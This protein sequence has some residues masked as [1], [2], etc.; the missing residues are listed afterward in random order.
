VRLDESK[1]DRYFVPCEAPPNGTVFPP[2][3]TYSK[4]NEIPTKEVIFERYAVGLT[5]KTNFDWDLEKHFAIRLKEVQKLIYDKSH[6]RITRWDLEKETKQYYDSV[7][8]KD[9]LK[10]LKQLSHDKFYEKEV[11]T[12]TIK[13]SEQIYIDTAYVYTVQKEQEFDLELM[14]KMQTEW[15]LKETASNDKSKY[16]QLDDLDLFDELSISSDSDFDSD[17][18]EE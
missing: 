9:S 14:E 5:I 16:T 8:K 7:D 11:T 3:F 6:K 4:M 2:D 13:E 18:I 15:L 1:V 12:S 10:N 17:N